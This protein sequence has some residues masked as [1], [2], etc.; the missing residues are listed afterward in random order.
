MNDIISTISVLVGRYTPVT[1]AH[2][3]L[4]NALVCAYDQDW[5]GC[6]VSLVNARN[7]MPAPHT[8]TAAEQIN[9]IIEG[10]DRLV[11]VGRVA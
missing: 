11:S 8:K 4:A 1:M 5:L 6:R 10:I 2:R 9:P 3:S 7:M